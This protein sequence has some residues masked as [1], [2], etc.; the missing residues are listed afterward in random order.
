MASHLDLEEQEQLAEL[1]HFWSTYGNLIS[2]VLIAVLGAYAAWNGW[3]YW[4]RHQASQAA[5]LYDEVERSVA[6]RDVQRMQRSLAEMQD[7]YANSMQAQQAT[8][9]VAKALADQGKTAEAKV[10][11]GWLVQKASDPVYADVARLRLASQAMQDKQYDEALEQLKGVSE[12]MQG[13]A[14]DMQGDLLQLQGKPA[15]AVVAYQ[16]AW[17]TLPQNTQSRRLLQAK[18]NALGAEPVS[19]EGNKS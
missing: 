7:R 10:T 3:N 9:L 6:S 16:K 8:Q 2:W 14:A 1:K 11:W 12:A 19:V 18:L 17:T 15:E 13:L 5:A 4:Q